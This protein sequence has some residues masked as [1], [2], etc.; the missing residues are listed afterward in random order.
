MEKGGVVGCCGGK[1]RKIVSIAAGN[2]NATVRALAD[3][4]SLPTE[5]Y[6]YADSRIRVC[7]CCEFKTWM[8][9]ME[10]AAWLRANAKE[11]AGNLEQLEAL[12]PLPIQEYKPGSKLVCSICKCWVVKKA[13]S[14]GEKCPLG[15]WQAVSR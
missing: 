12:P 9:T 10:F 15:Y 4:F 5:K 7:Q 11:I 14:T 1:I 3:L 2:A 13:Y 6:E 8:T